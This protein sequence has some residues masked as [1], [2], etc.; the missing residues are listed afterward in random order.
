MLRVRQPLFDAE[1]LL[2][3]VE[4]VSFF[5]RPLGAQFARC[6]AGRGDAKSHSDTNLSLS[7]RLSAPCK[8]NVL[9]IGFEHHYLEAT[10]ARAPIEER[11]AM[12]FDF[13]IVPKIVLP[14]IMR[15]ETYPMSDTQNSDPLHFS[16]ITILPGDTF[17]V[18]V[19]WSH[20]ITLAHPLYMRVWIDGWL[21]VPV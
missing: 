6:P 5:Q 16:G 13:G 8:F 19:F 21:W 9:G 12:E 2:G 14:L 1:Y 10:E 3:R 11:G 20:G 18:R 7:G 17:A 4:S 15:G